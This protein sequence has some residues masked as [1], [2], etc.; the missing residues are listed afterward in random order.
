MG[1][2]EPILAPN[3]ITPKNGPKGPRTQNWPR[4]MYWPFSTPGLWQP[5][6]ATSSSTASLHIHSGEGLSFTNLLHTKDSGMVHI[7]Y[8]IPLC[9][10]F[11]QKSNGDG[12]RIKLGLLNSSP[13]NTSPILK[14][15][16][17]PLAATI[18][19]LEDPKHLALQELGCTFL[20]RIIPREISRGCQ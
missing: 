14:E 4:T 18:G 1:P 9:T 10:I 13:Q 17:Q 5:P 20:F 16:L 6:E 8:N 19:P 11:A 3:L 2:P 15:V 7:W 12:F